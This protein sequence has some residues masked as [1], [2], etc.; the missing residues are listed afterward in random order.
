MAEVALISSVALTSGMTVA[1][2]VAFDTSG[3]TN[4]PMPQISATLAVAA[5]AVSL[6]G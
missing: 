4:V 2:D 3:E 1:D 6:H 5:L